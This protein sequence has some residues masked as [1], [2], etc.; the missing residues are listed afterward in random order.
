MGFVVVISVV[1]VNSVALVDVLIL[2]V[3]VR[4]VVSTL[5]L[6]FIIISILLK[7]V[8]NFVV[9]S[10]VVVGWTVV[11]GRVVVR[12]GL[13]GREEMNSSDMMQDSLMALPAL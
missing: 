10:V 4:V 12:E 9:S 2:T 3:D 8:L 13:V 11:V 1:D 6:L 5:Q 7:T